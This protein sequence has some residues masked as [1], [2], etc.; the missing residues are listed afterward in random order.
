MYIDQLFPEVVGDK[1][2]LK[3]LLLDAAASFGMAAQEAQT[4]IQ[5]LP[6][7]L[8]D[9]PGFLDT[10]TGLWRY[11]FGEPFIL[12]DQLTF[13]THMFLPVNELLLA[14]GALARWVPVKKRAAYLAAL[15]HPS[16]HPTALSEMM[17]VC[18]LPFTL[19]VDYEVSGY[20]PG[21][22]TVDW[23]LQAGGRLIL[24][25]VK[26]RTTDFIQQARNA[27][28]NGELPA[29]Q[30]NHNLMFKGLE[31]KFK[32]ADPAVQLQGAWITTHITQNIV[33]I[34]KAFAA[35]DSDKVHFAIFGD[36]QSDVSLLVRRELDRQ[37]L[38]GLFNVTQSQRF[39]FQP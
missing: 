1:A 15:N 25:D 18:R 2:P 11:E 3:L 24:L 14:T 33:E 6:S 39:F 12:D 27:A 31:D 26:S 16:K 10:S 38:L 8:I 32:A 5:L 28:Q 29:P 36:W 35:L 37:V 23:A 9:S 7:P 20:G 34:K 17:P 30:H 21:N 19:T 22:K 4:L 13:G